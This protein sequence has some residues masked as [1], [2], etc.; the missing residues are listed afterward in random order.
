[1][2]TTKVHRMHLP[3]QNAGRGVENRYDFGGKNSKVEL[4]L[5]TRVE[6]N[7]QRGRG[8]RFSEGARFSRVTMFFCKH[9]I[10][11]PTLLLIINYSHHYVYSNIFNMAESLTQKNHGS[12]DIQP[13]NF[14]LVGRPIVKVALFSIFLAVQYL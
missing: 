5:S 13:S 10:S 4:G 6:L 3:W 7:A 9:V 2:E 11:V 14:V 8:A 12:L 1:M